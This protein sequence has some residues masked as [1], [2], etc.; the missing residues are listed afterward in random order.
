MPT[1]DLVGTAFTGVFFLVIGSSSSESETTLAFLDFLV[2]ADF[3]ATSFFSFAVLAG[4]GLVSALP[5]KKALISDG[6]I[7]EC[8]SQL[9]CQARKTNEVVLMFGAW[10]TKIYLLQTV[11]SSL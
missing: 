3:D 10:S 6:M 11:Q 5:P 7:D 8:Q 4:E 9:L 1:Y 2:A